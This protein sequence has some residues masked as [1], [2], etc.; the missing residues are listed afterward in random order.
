MRSAARYALLAAGILLLNSIIL[1]ALLMGL[2][3]HP[4]PA[5]LLT[6]LLLFSF[7]YLVQQRLIFSDRKSPA[8][9]GKPE[10]SGI[11]YRIEERAERKKTKGE[12]KSY[13]LTAFYRGYRG[14]SL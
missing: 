14:S 5:K 1:S 4:F 6:E 12:D 11:E 8:E 13:A 2:H 9:A 10:E 7:S 3:M